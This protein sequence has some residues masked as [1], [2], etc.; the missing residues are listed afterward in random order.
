M[1]KTWKVEFVSRLCGIETHRVDISLQLALDIEYLSTWHN[2]LMPFIRGFNT[3]CRCR[4]F[5]SCIHGV[6]WLILMSFLE[7]LFVSIRISIRVS[8]RVVSEF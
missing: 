3:E 1:S 4:E 5:V 2:E 6:A 7:L 8:G